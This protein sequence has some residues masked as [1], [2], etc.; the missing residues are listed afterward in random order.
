MYKQELFGAEQMQGGSV[1]AGGEG[2]DGSSHRG[3][4]APRMLEMVSEAA[5]ALWT[6]TSSPPSCTLTPIF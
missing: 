5:C 6:L 3:D 1:G 4:G 2:G